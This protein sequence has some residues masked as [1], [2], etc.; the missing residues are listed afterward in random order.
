M[1]AGETLDAIVELEPLPLTETLFV[2]IHADRGETGV[3][4][5]DMMD[6]VNSPDQPFFTGAEEVATAVTVK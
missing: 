2:A 6:R 5:F 3:F 1:A 4:E